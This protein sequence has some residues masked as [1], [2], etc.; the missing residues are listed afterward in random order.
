MCV[1][2]KILF[3][4]KVTCRGTKFPPLSNGKE[5]L[6][7]SLVQLFRQNWFDP[8]IDLRKTNLCLYRTGIYLIVCRNS[9]KVVFNS[10]ALSFSPPLAF[11]YIQSMIVHRTFCTWSRGV[12]VAVHKTR[13]WTVEGQSF[14]VEIDGALPEIDDRLIA[15]KKF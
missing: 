3:T 6:V 7:Y 13:N 4:C 9:L 1:C 10:V 8:R 12:H 14:F 11:V 5:L 2:H 15:C